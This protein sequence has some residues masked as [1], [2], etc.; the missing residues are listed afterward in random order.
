MIQLGSLPGQSYPNRRPRN[1][2]FEPEEIMRIL[3]ESLTSIHYLSLASQDINKGLILQVCWE[4]TQAVPVASCCFR[5]VVVLLRFENS[6]S[7]VSTNF[8]GWRLRRQDK[9]TLHATPILSRDV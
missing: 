2:A 6:S 5:A 3:D 1:N 9:L 4:V 7:V 8:S